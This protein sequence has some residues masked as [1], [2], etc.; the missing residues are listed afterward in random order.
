MRAWRD[1]E[2]RGARGSFTRLHS[3]PMWAA[4]PPPPRAPL[5]PVSASRRR[6]RT[7]PLGPNKLPS[8]LAFAVQ[9]QRW[10]ETVAGICR[11]RD[12]LVGDQITRFDPNPT[13]ITPTMLK[14]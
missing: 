14:A 6:L 13:E 5:G 12:W 4:S 1:A 8:E 2:E 11:V 9:F 3:V 7:A 10:N